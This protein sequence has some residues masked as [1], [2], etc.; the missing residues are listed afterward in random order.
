MGEVV[1]LSLQVSFGGGQKV[2]QS[3]GNP[4][5]ENPFHFRLKNRY[6]LFLANAPPQAVLRPVRVAA[7]P[8]VVDLTVRTDGA[9]STASRDSAC[10]D[11]CSDMQSS[12]YII[13]TIKWYRVLAWPFPRAPGMNYF[14]WAALDP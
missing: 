3:T 12:Y 8:D 4:E 2:V 14:P 6:V 13:S 5:E 1:W 7:A 11:H 10:Q 9:S